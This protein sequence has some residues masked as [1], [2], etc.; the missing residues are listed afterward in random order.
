MAD[1]EKKEE[2]VVEEVK[3]EE[4][5]PE[6]KE[7]IVEEKTEKVEEKKTP[8]EKPNTKDP[9]KVMVRSNDAVL[10]QGDAQSITTSNEYGDMDILPGHVEFI[11]LIFDKLIIDTG[12][13]KDEEITLQSGVVRVFKNQV[14]I[15][16][17]M[18]AVSIEKTAKA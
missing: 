6:V 9:L 15:F 10:F 5:K 17:G 4:K 3:V 16:L 2:K 7:T 11:S 13:E 14:D 18:D 12:K 8:K 1:K